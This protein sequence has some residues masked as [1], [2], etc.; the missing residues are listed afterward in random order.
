M[1]DTPN[2]RTVVLSVFGAAAAAG[3]FELATPAMAAEDPELARR[4]KELSESGNSTC[5]AKFTGSIATMPAT[6]RIKGSCCSPMQ[7]KRYGEQVKGLA[8]YR[9]IP[10]IPGDPYDI[11]VATAQQM[12]PC[13]DLKLTGDEQKAYDY[14]MANSEEKGPCCCPCWRWK[15]YGGLAKYLIHEHRFT[16]EQIVDVWDLSDGCGGGM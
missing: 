3:L 13:Y 5:S 11:A 8:K 7:Q 14:A 4:F 9:T 12:M 1:T 16:G 2:R 10:M 15:V 6:A